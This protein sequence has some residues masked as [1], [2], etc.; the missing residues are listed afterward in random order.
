MLDPVALKSLY[1]LRFTFIT[2]AWPPRSVARGGSPFRC[3]FVRLWDW[4]RA[5]SSTSAWAPPVP[6]WPPRRRRRAS[7]PSSRACQE[8]GSSLTQVASKPWISFAVKFPRGMWIERGQWPQDAHNALESLLLSNLPLE[9]R[10][11]SDHVSVVW[12]GCDMACSQLPKL[13]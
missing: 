2:K 10:Y 13:L 12:E 1:L 4:N 11:E 5:P 9:A 8:S 6:F 7:L 3:R